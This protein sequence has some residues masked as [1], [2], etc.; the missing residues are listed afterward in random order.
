MSLGSKAFKQT[1]WMHIHWANFF[2][3]EAS[4]SSE[5]GLAS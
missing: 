3:T 2:L 1:F 4:S 5:D